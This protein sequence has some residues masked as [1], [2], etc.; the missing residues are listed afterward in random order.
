MAETIYCEFEILD[1]ISDLAKK[2]EGEMETLFQIPIMKEA[3]TLASTNDNSSGTAGVTN[4][5]G[6]DSTTFI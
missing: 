2:K 3:S 5:V 4:P 1:P 6:N